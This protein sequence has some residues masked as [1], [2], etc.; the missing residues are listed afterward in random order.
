[1]TG[2]RTIADQVYDRLRH[3]IVRLAIRPGEKLSEA[4]IADR[5]KVSR[6][7][8]REAFIHLADDGFLL[9]RP[10]R[11]TV[12]KPISE[13]AVMNAQFVREAVE[14]AIVAEAASRWGAADRRALSDLIA[15]Q[16]R[17]AKADDRERF[18][19]LDEDFHREIAER[20]GRLAAWETVDRHKA[21]MDRVRFLSLGFGT[22]RVIAEH[23]AIA[24]ALAAQD[25]EGAASAMRAH[26]SAI[27]GFIGA[28][29][30]AHPDC[31]AELP[32]V[33]VF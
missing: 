1:M 8:V 21:E 28:V 20:A 25:A 4:E 22:P 32:V 26:L 10:Q 17:A 18:H 30:A 14:A 3:D 27:K 12:V 24:G 11:P 29:R 2:R 19:N 16:E 13:A 7:P 6:Q 33:E 23:R 9:I 31:F 5:F 15:E